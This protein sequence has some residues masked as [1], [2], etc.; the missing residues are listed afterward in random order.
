MEKVWLHTSVSFECRLINPKE[1]Q[2]NH[3]QHAFTVE[4][5]RKLGKRAEAAFDYLLCLAIGVGLAA[6]LV[7]W[8]SS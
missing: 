3:T 5:H 2:M 4:N 7:A 6:L 1:S 8:W